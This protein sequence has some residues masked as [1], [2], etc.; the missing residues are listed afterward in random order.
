MSLSEYLSLQQQRI[1]A[2]LDA[3]VPPE[4]EPPHSI[5]KAMRYSLFAG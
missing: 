3:C 1:D 2:A 5:H 4:T